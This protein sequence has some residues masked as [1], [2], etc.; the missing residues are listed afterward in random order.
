MVAFPFNVGRLPEWVSFE[1]GVTLGVSS[2]AAAAALFEGLEIQSPRNSSPRFANNDK[3]SPV[4][5]SRW[6]LVWGGSCVTGMMVIQLAK[7]N[8][9]NVF[10]VAGLQNALY[11]HSLGADKVV[12]RCEPENAIA[13][14][15]KLDIGLGID[16]VGQQTATHAIQALQP[17]GRLVYLV[18]KP[19]LAVVEASQT[20]ITDIVIKRF[21]EDP[22]YGQ[23]LMDYISQCLYSRTIRPV[24]HE[25]VQGGLDVVERGLAILKN[26]RVSGRKLVILVN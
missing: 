5:A 19:E 1:E 11:L 3:I 6:I 13:E 7:L 4:G 2:V 14:A 24:R 15:R 17:G 23:F 8:G 20:E 26:Q 22:A 12:D 18:K 25:V 16:C 21:H 9:F 10:A